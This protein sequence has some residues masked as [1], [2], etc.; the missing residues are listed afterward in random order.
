MVYI[1]LVS[2]IGALALPYAVHCQRYLVQQQQAA[3]LFIQQTIAGTVLMHDIQE[4]SCAQQEWKKITDNI[5]IFHKQEQD[6]GWIIEDK[7]LFRIEGIYNSTGDM[8]HSSTKSFI[9][10][11]I[12][13]IQV[14]CHIDQGNANQIRAVTATMVSEKSKNNKI[15]N[16]ISHF[17]ALNNRVLS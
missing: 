2:F 5:I 1:T 7:K 8:W 13:T 16:K 6:I 15:Q 9:A 11:N 14:V 10:S 3:R 12:E 17:I 4:A